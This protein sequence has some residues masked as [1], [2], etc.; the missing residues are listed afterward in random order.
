MFGRRR[1][2]S[3]TS[4]PST[5]LLDRDHRHRALHRRD[6]DCR[7]DAGPDVARANADGTL[8]YTFVESVKA[9]YPFYVIRLGGACCSW[10]ACA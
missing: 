9:T 3:P 7:C 6:V 4:A 8:V 10:P 5:A 1:R 2:C